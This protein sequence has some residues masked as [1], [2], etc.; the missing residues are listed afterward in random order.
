MVGVTGNVGKVGRGRGVGLRHTGL[1]VEGRGWAAAMVLVGDL[2][3]GD[4]GITCA[5][6]FG[7][8]LGFL[9][10]RPRG[11][12]LKN[13]VLGFGLALGWGVALG[14]GASSGFGIA[15]GVRGTMPEVEGATT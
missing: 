10:V 7:W 12:V 15:L 3:V 5:L 6:G 14:K 13:V 8:G 2:K 9:V 1:G 11:M 4:L